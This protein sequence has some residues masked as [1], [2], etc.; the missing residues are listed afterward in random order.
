M[1]E[2]QNTHDAFAPGAGASPVMDGD[3]HVPR[4]TIAFGALPD[5]SNAAL[6]SDVES[7][8][9][10]D[11]ARSLK[12]AF[13]RR[14]DYS[15]FLCTQI[16]ARG[17]IPNA[18]LVLSIGGWG[19]KGDVGKDVKTWYA[20]VA[21]RSAESEI[22]LPASLRRPAL[23][24]IEELWLVA[25]RQAQNHIAADRDK[26]QAALDLVQADLKAARE[27]ALS[28]AAA[29]DIVVAQ[30]DEAT[31]LAQDLRDQLNRA[32]QRA[33]EAA[34]RLDAERMAAS[35]REEAMRVQHAQEIE[36]SRTQ[37]RDE[38]REAQDKLKSSMQARIDEALAEKT[39]ATGEL[40]QAL[41]LVTQELGVARQQAREAAEAATRQA[42]QMALSLDKARQEALNA[43]QQAIEAQK[44]QTSAATELAELRI[45]MSLL[46]RDISQER[47]KTLRLQEALEAKAADPEK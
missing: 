31:R 28:A 11:A 32:E 20:Q 6:P 30:R 36:R 37:L 35:Q 45:R 43:A 40:K 10:V 9:F 46:E 41:D 18:T 38:H 44:A 13:E 22:A 17:V 4:E 1:N 29:R 42:H 19:S 23:Q 3:E 26:A 21:R 14:E 16:A 47:A 2:H 33:Q 5:L 8:A 15:Q 39:K 27:E 34:E 24:L 7:Q 12:S 25:A